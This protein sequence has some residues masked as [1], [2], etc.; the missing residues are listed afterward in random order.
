MV[1]KM[2]FGKRTGIE[3]PAETAGI[4][5]NPD[6]WNG[7]SLA[8]M[9]IGYEIGVTPLQIATAFATIANDGIK[10][11]PHIIKEI[12]NSEG[13]TISIT[14]P[15]QTQVVSRETAE[16]LRTMLRQ[17]VLSGTGRRAQLDGYTS[18]GK[19]GTAWKFD[20]KTKRVER[21]KYIS[22]FVGFA[23][24]NDPKY[25]IIVVMD[26]PKSG[27]RDGGSVA[28]PVFKDIAQQLLEGAK[29]PHDLT[30][31]ST[32]VTSVDVPE[33]APADVPTVKGPPE[34][35]ENTPSEPNEKKSK[36][37]TEVP[38][39]KESSKPLA[40]KTAALTATPKSETSGPAIWKTKP[41]T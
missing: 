20:P 23:P 13:K 38:L 39:K 25:V 22:S 17:V 26:E 16:D 21:S 18:A 10:N 11:Q 3:L 37:K 34:E 41:K 4:V 12:R 14:E 29:V 9:S 31:S 28:A 6:K 15:N 7:D 19:T 5:R 27:A 33:V 35:K 30:A 24:A 40:D 2:G 8:S 36:T 1:Q 32:A